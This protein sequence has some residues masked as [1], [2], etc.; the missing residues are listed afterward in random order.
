MFSE[1]M[2]IKGGNKVEWEA[3]KPT[4]PKAKGLNLSTD[5]CFI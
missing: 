1:G 5:K 3:L 2:S 4:E